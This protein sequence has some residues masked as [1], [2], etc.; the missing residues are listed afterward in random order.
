MFTEENTSTISDSISLAKAVIAFRE[1]SNGGELHSILSKM[2]Y[3]AFTKR[4]YSL[5]KL[6]RE[7]REDMMADMIEFCLSKLEKKVES[8]TDRS[9]DGLRV[10]NKSAFNYLMISLN[11]QIMCTYR[12]K[13]KRTQLL[14]TNAHKVSMAATTPMTQTYHSI[15]DRT[16]VYSDLIENPF[17]AEVANLLACKYSK[18]DIAKL[19]NVTTKK[20]YSA[21]ERI[22]KELSNNIDL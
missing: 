8:P 22:K 14:E 3:A 16:N 17:D 12:Q 9:F 19:L 15:S 13:K 11:Y 6:R 4:G 18:V 5:T 1:E 7:E 10:W 2:V 21:I 20:V